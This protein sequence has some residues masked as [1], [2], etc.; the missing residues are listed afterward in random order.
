M[1]IGLPMRPADRMGFA[2]WYTGVNDDVKELLAIINVDAGDS[3]GLEL[4]YNLAINKWLHI[5]GD[6]QLLQSANKRDSVA[7]IP[8]VR[9]VV[10]F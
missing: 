6:L 5:T 8:G 7:V 2:G 9:F 4:Y 10:D 1:L 3:W